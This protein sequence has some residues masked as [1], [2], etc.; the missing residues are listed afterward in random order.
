MQTLDFDFALFFV[1]VFSTQVYY[2]MVLFLR[3]P[4]TRQSVKHIKQ[5]MLFIEYL[6]K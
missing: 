1:F 4:G 3:D 6:E 5:R 2:G